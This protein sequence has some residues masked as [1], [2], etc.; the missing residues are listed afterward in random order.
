MNDSMQS[1]EPWMFQKLDRLSKWTVVL[2]T[3]SHPM[4]FIWSLAFAN[5]ICV[6]ASVAA[7]WKT[8]ENPILKLP[9]GVWKPISS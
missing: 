9:E 8:G 1:D 4:A 6:G 5:W 2:C 7:T 3:V